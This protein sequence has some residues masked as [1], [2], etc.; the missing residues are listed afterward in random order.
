MPELPE[1]E[2]LVRR[3]RPELEGRTITAIDVRWNRTIDRLPPHQFARALT[4]AVIVRCGRRGKFLRFDLRCPDHVQRTW[5][6]HLRMSGSL[7][8]DGT[9]S[10]PQLHDRVILHLSS[11]KKLRFHDPRKFG[12]MYCVNDA[13]SPVKHLGPEPFD[14]ELERT[15]P[16]RLRSRRGAIKSLLLKQDFLA[17]V[18]NI[19]A[20]EALW[21][22]GIHPQR[23]ADRISLS[24]ATQLLVA[25]VECLNAAI[26]AQGTD[27]GDHVVVGD[28]VPQVYGRTGQPCH[29][30]GT[31]IKR[32]VVGQRGTH[33][34]PKCQR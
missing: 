24:R 11:R 15:F 9:H 3:L 6:V 29:R 22:A 31:P 30:C 26:A 21:R 5:Y 28:Y 19:Y 17:G 7:I 20:D 33:F 1:V 16:E 10:L 34:C 2:S 14:P 23:S 13:Q 32:I 8:I 27:F 18:G 4:G 12:R 25:I